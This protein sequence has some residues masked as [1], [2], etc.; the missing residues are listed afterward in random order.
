M[1]EGIYKDGFYNA[2]AISGLAIGTL[3]QLITKV[4]NVEQEIKLLKDK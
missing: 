4:E 1:P 2:G 3:K